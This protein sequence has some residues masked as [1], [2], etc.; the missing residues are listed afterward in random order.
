MS[1]APQKP[2]SKTSAQL[3]GAGAVA[4]NGGAALAAR[5]VQVKGSV[6]GNVITGTHIV[7]QYLAAGPAE[8]D[9]PAIAEQITRYLKWLRERTQHIT[10]RGIERSGG[11][12]VVQMPLETAY[13]PLRARPQALPQADDDSAHVIAR[14]AAGK[15]PRARKPESSPED[16]AAE[17]QD[18]DIPLDQLL[19]LGQRLVIVGGP[20]SGKTTVLLHL[21]WAL[22]C[23]L[24]EGSA[25][26]AQGRLGLQ[27]P[28]AA[29]PLPLFVPLASFARY[30]RDLPPNT[31]PQHKTLRHFISH[32]LVSQQAGFRLPVDF[33]ERLLD[34]GHHVLL[35]LDGLDEVAN[36]NERHSVRQ[37]VETLVQG[38]DGLRTVVTCRTVAYRQGRTALG[39]AFREVAVQPLDHDAHIVPMVQQA[40]ACIHPHD[41]AQRDKRAGSLLA[42]I[43]RL[44]A[45]RQARGGSQAEPLVSSPLMV[46]LLL[47]VHVNQ[48]ELPNQ[49]ADLF[50]KAIAAL[51]QVDYGHDEDDIAELGAQWETLL[52]MAQHVAW[53]LHS[54]G[55]EQGREIDEAG[56]KA[57]LRQTPEFADHASAFINH[58]R[59][60]GSLIEERDGAYRFIHLALQEFL[61]ARHL[62]EVVAGTQGLAALVDM[63]RPRLTDPWWREPILL[64][65]GYRAGQAAHQVREL[66]S[67]LRDA[68]GQAGASLDTALAA[69]ELAGTAAADWPA[70]GAGLRQACAAQLHALLTDDA[71]LR[72]TKPSQRARAGDAL[73][74]LGDPRFDPERFFLPADEQLG[75]APIPEDREFMIGTRPQDAERVA[76]STGD[77]AFKDEFNDTTTPTSVFHIARYP[78]TVAQFRSFAD[79]TGLQPGDAR[80]LS[81]P[82]T[83]PVRWVSWTEASDYCAWLQQ[84]L[85]EAPALAH[86]PAARLVRDQDWRVALPSELQ[87][88]KAA[89]GGRVGQVFPWGDDHDRNLANNGES[90]VGNTSAVGCF[91]ANDFGL[92]DMIGN[93]WQWTSSPWVETYGAKMLRAEALKPGVDDRLVV[94]GG[95]WGDRRDFARCAYRFRFTP[96]DRFYDLGFRVVLRS[97]PV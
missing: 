86:T 90:G 33:F 46:R 8:M 94:R 2:R 59:Q 71:T 93:V 17:D 97:S 11:A 92:F 96:D 70:S 28:P 43:R 82:D 54:Q 15:S 83:R 35:L 84:M 30:R 73:A 27:L 69:A 3:R 75:F 65:M 6:G 40:Y 49:R 48:R 12:P 5:A 74:R 60:R 63:V 58:A 61:V 14:R 44:E 57:A 50:D 26:L 47:I 77:E 4:Q 51:L 29:L 62:R 42:G 1:G 76:R 87:W 39:A 81:D 18:R 67:L 24:L 25:E 68:G 21:A 85:R 13:V 41:P 37:Q 56:L 91:A 55:D 89:R 7:N 20:G 45:D 52:D 38:H 32:H 31:P 10:L 88:E 79:A 23:S 95:S 34:D 36:E 16:A 22:A 80:T 78:V 66:I 9:A 19:A 72:H 53:H 64:A